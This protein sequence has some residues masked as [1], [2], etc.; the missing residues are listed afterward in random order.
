MFNKLKQSLVIRDDLF[1]YLQEMLVK[2]NDCKSWIKQLGIAA[3]VTSIFW[4][5]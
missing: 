1:N 2:Q 3:F 4:R 5:Q